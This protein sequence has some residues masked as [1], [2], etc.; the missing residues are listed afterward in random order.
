MA[1]YA[2]LAFVSLLIGLLLTVAS[3][4]V[5]AEEVIGGGSSSTVP[6]MA[7]ARVCIQPLDGVLTCYSKQVSGL[8]ARGSWDRMVLGGRSQASSPRRN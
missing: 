3:P 7:G 6:M 5:G 8:W 2:R 1:R 4:A